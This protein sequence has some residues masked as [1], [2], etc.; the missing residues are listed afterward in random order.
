MSSTATLGNDHMKGEEGVI[1]EE[2]IDSRHCNLEP[3][4][5]YRGRLGE[6]GATH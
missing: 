2:G 3:S 6:R 5:G 1:R 4:S